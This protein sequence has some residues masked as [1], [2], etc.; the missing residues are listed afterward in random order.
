M[1]SRKLSPGSPETRKAG[2][3]IACPLSAAT[4]AV[5]AAQLQ[6]LAAVAND[7]EHIH[8]A[9]AARQKRPRLSPAYTPT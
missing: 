5:P 8:F 4:A 3:A 2:S 6:R 7:D 9:S 1:Y